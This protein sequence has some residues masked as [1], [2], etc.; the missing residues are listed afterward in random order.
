MGVGDHQVHQ[1]VGGERR[2]PGERLVDP[3]RACRRPRPAG[4]RARSG[5]RAAARAAAGRARP[6]RA[7]PRAAAPA[8]SASGT[9]ACSGSR[10]ARRSLPSRICSRCSA[11]QVWKPLA[12]AEMPR[13]ACMLT[14][15]PIICSWRRPKA[16][17]QG[18]SST[19]GLGERGLRELGRDPADRRRRDAGRALRPRRG[20]RPDRGSARP[21]A[22]T[23][24]T[25]VPLA[26]AA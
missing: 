18:W 1:A 17:V 12:W 9:A 8:G 21:A 23:P 6:R 19:T 25:R 15:R 24:G 13:I 7:G 16:S 20:R 5:S 22:G 4:P 11:R 3:R 14:G 2:F 26:A 10:P